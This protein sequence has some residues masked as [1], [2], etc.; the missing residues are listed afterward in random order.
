ME[1][2]AAKFKS[3]EK[4]TG[5]RMFEIDNVEVSLTALKNEDKT[6]KKD[7]DIDQ[8]KNLNTLEK[9]AGLEEMN[10]AVTGIDL[11]G[12]GMHKVNFQAKHAIIEHTGIKRKKV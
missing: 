11:P 8:G 12:Q 7:T 6:V 4:T 3:A 10:E 1:L 5:S 9:G 2:E